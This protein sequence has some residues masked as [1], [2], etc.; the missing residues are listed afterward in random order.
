VNWNRKIRVLAGAA[1]LVAATSLHVAAQA[2]TPTGPGILRTR[3]WWET[4]RT[5]RRKRRAGSR[6]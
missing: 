4:H 6:I 2:P 5:W 1:A 3:R